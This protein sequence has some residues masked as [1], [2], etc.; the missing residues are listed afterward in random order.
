MSNHPQDE[1]VRDIIG[2]RD[3]VG[4]LIVAVL[5]ALVIGVFGGM[6]P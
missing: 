4:V 2:H 3:R 1:V 5:L 6:L